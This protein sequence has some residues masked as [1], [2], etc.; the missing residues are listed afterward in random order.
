M[1]KDNQFQFATSQAVDGVMLL[2]A[3]MTD[4]SYGRHA[5]EEFSFGVTLAGRQDFFTQGEQRHSYPGNV[6]V[7]NPDD[8]HDGESGSDDTL[9][10]QMLYVHPNQ[11]AP[12][13]DAVGVRQAELFRIGTPVLEDPLLRHQI[14]QLASL[15][16]DEDTSTFAYTSA[17]FEFA[18][19]L[20]R[21]D[22]IAPLT[23]NKQRDILLLRARD[24]LYDNLDKE[25]SLDDLSQAV[26]M[27]KFHLLRH[28][29]Q[30]FGMT[31]YQF[32]LN[33]R[34]NKARQAL[35]SGKS[36]QDVAMSFGF[37]DVSHFNRRFKPIFGTTP[38]QYQRFLAQR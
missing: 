6:L 32:W 34:I 35:L 8:A 27:S 36:V 29:K 24:Y 4:F 21:F 18:E 31:P 17:M 13:L 7:F 33:G 15:V 20:A 16:K 22:G 25:I 2:S 9:R 3:S 26:H 1:P 30:H 19:Q 14:L 10:Y 11:L 23:P 28:F 37:N 12:F 5:H 38:R